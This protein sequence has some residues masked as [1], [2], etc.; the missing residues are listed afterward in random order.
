MTFERCR[1]KARPTMMRASD[2]TRPDDPK[3]PDTDGERSGARDHQGRFAP[4]NRSALG[5]GLIRATKKLV[6]TREA[7]GDARIVARDARRIA[8]HVLRAFPSDAAPVRVLVALH[9]R[10]VALNAYFTVK[11]EEAGLDTERGLELLTVASRESQRAERTLVTAQ[12][13]ARVCADTAA[14]NRGP[15]DLLAAFR[16]PPKEP[17]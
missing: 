4:R 17:Q 6:G 14:R 10:H 1:G 15:V 8:A 3:K 7:K 11:A 9:A 16:T 5:S 12:D 13:M 2:L